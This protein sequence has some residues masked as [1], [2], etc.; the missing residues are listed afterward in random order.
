MNRIIL[1]SFLLISGTPVCQTPTN[2]NE[3]LEK[4]ELEL[5]QKLKDSI[6]ILDEKHFTTTSHF[7]LGFNIRGLW[8]LNGGENDLFQFFQQLGLKHPDD[9]SDVILTSLHRKLNKKDINLNQQ[10]DS[11]R[12]SYN[13]R[14]K[15]TKS[16]YPKGAENMD[17]NMEYYYPK[18]GYYGKAF[19]GKIPNLGTYWLYE[20]D[21]GWVKLSQDDFDKFYS[22][23]D[24]DKEK[25]II[26]FSKK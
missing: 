17:L 22:T 8:G 26:E 5:P 11:Y 15:P 19:V 18:D 9:M 13:A 24:E 4:L 20:V 1:L 12:K 7:G 16:N 23:P 3:G 25:L 14:L 2:L 21:Y 6:R 10:I